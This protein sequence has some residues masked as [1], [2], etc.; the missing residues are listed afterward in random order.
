[1][2][3]GLRRSASS[4]KLTETS[5]ISDHV[6]GT[7][8]LAKLRASGVRVSLD[9][10]GTGYSSLAYLAQLPLDEIKLDRGFLATGLGTDG[11]LMRSIVNIGQ[12]L[13]ATV[14][15]EGV[16]TEDVL[17][18]VVDCGCDVVQGYIYARPLPP[19]DVA[20]FIDRW[21][22]VPEAVETA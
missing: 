22:H 4:S 19:D 20:A 1:M 14:V 3:R 12:H 13:G 10:F 2:K 16:E 7:G 15:A 8:T 21:E 9:D 18:Q 17:A 5:A 6:R 11:F